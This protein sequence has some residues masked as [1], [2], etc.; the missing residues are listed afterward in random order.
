MLLCVICARSCYPALSCKWV[1]INNYTT[2]PPFASLSKPGLLGP[3]VPVPPPA[4]SV[5]LVSSG[6]KFRVLG[7][8]VVDL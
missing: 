3:D 1:L 8:T 5:A 6:S 4:V 7:P 2:I